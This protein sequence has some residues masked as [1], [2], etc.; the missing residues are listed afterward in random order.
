MIGVCLHLGAALIASLATPQIALE[1]TH[2][3]YDVPVREHYRVTANALILERYESTTAVLEYYGMNPLPLTPYPEVRFIADE[4]GRHALVWDGQRLELGGYGTAMRLRPCEVSAQTS[5]GTR[6]SLETVLL[7][8][9][10]LE[11]VLLETVLLKAMQ[12]ETG[13]V[14][15]VQLETVLLE[16]GSINTVQLEVLEGRLL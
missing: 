8:T 10:L 12:L 5:S 16:A 2:S 7:E 6:R 9:V 4:I 15:T 1:Y 11:T 13:L 3:M 14:K